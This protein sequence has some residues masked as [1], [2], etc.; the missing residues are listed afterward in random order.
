MTRT[1][2]ICVPAM[3]L[4]TITVGCQTT[5]PLPP[6]AQQS[7]TSMR[8]AVTSVRS[9]TNAA[10]NS[11][12]TL[13]NNR[14]NIEANARTFSQELGRL[15]NS[16][17]QARSKTDPAA[18][19][20]FFSSWRDELRTINNTQLRQAGEQRF[21]SARAGMDQLESHIAALRNDFKP[22]YNDMQE[23]S[24]LLQKDPTAA[25]LNSIAPTARRILG[26]RNTVMSRFDAVERQIARML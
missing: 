10:F 5:A 21:E 9:E 2:F 17:D 22:L 14:N 11:L 7:L 3:I 16:I 24:T 20:E 23:I 4:M 26:Q 6:Q 19:D 18:R 15:T 12:Q 25:G 1:P 8:T 13:I